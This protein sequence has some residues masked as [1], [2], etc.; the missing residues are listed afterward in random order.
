MPSSRRVLA[1]AL[2]STALVAGFSTA[3]TAAASSAVIH[4][5]RS[6]G[7]QETPPKQAV[8]VGAGGAVSSVD[9][10]ATAVGI[11]V[12]RQGGTA[13]DAAVA[14]AAALGVTEPYSA[15]I[16]GGGYLVYYNARTGEVTTLDGRETA[17]LSMSHDAFIDPSTGQP[18]NFTPELV[19]SGV[20]VG[21]P[22]TPGLWA[23]ATRNWGHRTF[24]QDMR[25]AADLARRGFVV[26][27][28]FNLQ[29]RENAVRFAAITSTRALYLPGG[30]APAVGST[31]R[32]PDL[33]DTYD[34]L[35]RKGVRVLYHGWLGAEIVR[36]VQH[37]PKV[38][39][40]E[41]PVMPGTMTRADL[42]QYSAIVRRPTHIYYRGYTIDGM[43][44]SSSGGTT[45]SEALNILENFDLG[46]MPRVEALNVYL[47]AS[48]RAY[49]DRNAYIGDPA[50]VD[51]PE[52]EL[53]S[54]GFA[55]ER[56]CT[57]DPLQASP[58]PVAPGEPDG[59]YQACSLATNDVSRS[60][61]EGLSTSHLV[62]A[63]RW[64]DV[65][66]YTLTIEQTGGSGIVVPGRGFL[67]NN[68]LTDFTAVYNP[69]DPNRIEGG[70][71][72]R[73]S[74]SPTIV[75]RQGRPFL[76]IGSPG[77][78][79]IITTVLQ[80]LVNYLDFG[81]PLPASIEAPRASQRNAPTTTA[82]QA[83]IDQYGAALA[84]YGQTFAVPGLPGT[85][86]AQIG[87]VTAIRLL[88]G[89]RFLAAAEQTRRGGGSAA[90]VH[91]D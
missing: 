8:A 17:P 3:T 2:V 36:T 19:T 73:S 29:T 74:M 38:E 75:L 68:E 26:D 15:G 40:T 61:T 62:A 32:N 47:E 58:K 13:A 16:G 45:V 42:A 5:S 4:Q 9:A 82:E 76:A 7:S 43:A 1:A 53:L 27:P 22:G 77:G 66:S 72:P 35:A 70:K 31:F 48:A 23:S 25:P 78:A 87:A 37:P 57:I 24:A 54:Q 39:D 91:P 55:N 14:T 44:P 34:L 84:Q 12:L 52:H 64:G 21:V 46:F 86:A 50:Y 90:V 80:T 65:A 28:T 88:P 49:A 79:T 51:V 60:D 20:S 6:P 33:G 83:F 56:A 63:D 11:R 69:A 41:L 10:D 85:S 59:S 18:Y 81:M 71:R 30:N 89:D 67:L